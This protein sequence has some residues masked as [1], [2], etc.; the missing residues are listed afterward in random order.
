MRL[1]FLYLSD[2]MCAVCL[3]A[4]RDWPVCTVPVML[5]LTDWIKEMLSL[6]YEFQ[7]KVVLKV[8]MIS[9]S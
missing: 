1:L 3:I 4:N 9:H 5:D 8:R 7:K 6:L 2:T